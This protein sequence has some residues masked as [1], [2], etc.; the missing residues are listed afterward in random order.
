MCDF[1][2]H[3]WIRN[4]TTLDPM[5]SLPRLLCS[6]CSTIFD[7]RYYYRGTN[8]QDSELIFQ[9]TLTGCGQFE[10]PKGSYPLPSGW[11]F[12]VRANDPSYTYYYPPAR[13]DH[14][15]VLWCMISIG[16]FWAFFEEM[17]ARHGHVYPIPK[18]SP[19]IRDLLGFEHGDTVSC[20][21]TASR[22]AEL[23]S[24]LLYTMMA[25]L[26]KQK[27]NTSQEYLIERATRMINEHPETLF[28]ATE[29]SKRLN[30]TREH[31]SRLFK[32][33]LKTTP[34]T[35]ILKNKIEAAKLSLR[36][37]TLSLKEI[38]HRL[39]FSSPQQFSCVFKKT[40]GLSPRCFR[41][42]KIRPL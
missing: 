23:V 39:G 1:L 21:L 12:I 20:S 36:S 28:T 35:Y 15:Q 31:L 14:W 13:T 42:Q 34:Y 5:E 18:E 2:R 16:G 27:S 25:G 40:T 38:A 8:R 11:A 41:Q 22:G 10:D 24:N 3:D 17:V 30:I 26:E 4:L 33:R 29:L 19:I 7:K 9:Y 6:C 37:N 32:H